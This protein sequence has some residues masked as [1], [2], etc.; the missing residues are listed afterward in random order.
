MKR[1]LTV[2]VL[3]LVAGA[4]HA[5]PPEQIYARA[6]ELTWQV[7][8][9]GADEKL[10]AAASGIVVA[11][12][13]VVTSCGTLARA[14]QV[15]LRRGNTIFDAK[16]EFPDVERDLCQLDAPGLGGL[17]PAQ[18]S[19]STLRP[20]QKLYVIGFGLGA[21][22]TIG[23]GLV[24][25]VHDAG[26]GK[27]R[28]Q[29]TAP[30]ARGLL[31]AGVYD[32][33]AK[34]VGV[35][36]VSPKEAA[37]SLFAVPADWVPEVAARG[38]AALAA[39]SKPAA[40]TPGAVAAAP[41]MPAA[42]TTW[43]YGYIERIFGRRQIEYS[44][45]VLRVIDAVVEEALTFAG[46]GSKD[47]R[48]VVDARE[49]RFLEQRL[50]ANAT[51]IELAPYLVAASNGKE[52][53]APLRPM[54]YPIGDATL[55]DWLTSARLLDWEQV[56]VPAGTFRA[57]RVEI[58][59]KRER[60]PF[61]NHVVAGSFR[62]TAWYAP[63]VQRLVRLEHQVRGGSISGSGGLVAHDVVELLKYSPGS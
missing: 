46:S 56:T 27:D 60:P 39:R 36:T 35:V 31:G 6:A 17:A 49:A 23:E 50:D 30:S 55:S 15:Q 58:D 54:G 53:A 52:P 45:R 29:T 37:A 4:A 38:Q 59:G 43:V 26:T 2:S 14:Q 57:L 62:L 47:A 1:V 11:P 5:L 13:K 48:R 32:E 7:R 8:A 40:A 41:G 22:L 61:T 19:A 34:L 51:L 21:A 20:G 44:V 28:I 33:D 9:L 3:C 25:A 16:L 63:E 24:S 10:L 18:G 42:G 12:G